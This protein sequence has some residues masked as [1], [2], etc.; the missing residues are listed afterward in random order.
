[1]SDTNGRFSYDEITRLRVAAGFASVGAWVGGGNAITVPLSPTPDEG[2]NGELIAE[3][4]QEKNLSHIEA[5]QPANVIAFLDQFERMRDAWANSKSQARTVSVSEG[6]AWKARVAELEKL[7]SETRGVL[8]AIVLTVEGPPMDE[9][10]PHLAKI[11]RELDA[12]FKEALQPR[13]RCTRINCGCPCEVCKKPT[14]AAV[15]A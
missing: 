6:A 4:I 12:K 14:S 5:W 3:S 2:Y 9:D 11:V 10:R 7:M 15:P 13:E 1:V 8:G